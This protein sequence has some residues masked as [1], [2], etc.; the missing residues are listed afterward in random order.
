MNGKT[1]PQKCLTGL[2]T[3]PLQYFQVTHP[4]HPLCGQK[5]ELITRRNNWG[6]DRVFYYNIEQNF[7][8]MPVSWTSA[9]APDL[10]IMQS[11]GRALFRFDDLL[12]LARLLQTLKEQFPPPANA[13][14]QK[15]CKA[16][17]AVTVN[18]IM[19]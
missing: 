17:N 4:F 3:T 11:A 16:N 6:D 15:R 9:A 13:K 14:R 5:F 10:F 18:D 19:P 2:S 12:P 7:V 1:V 8:S